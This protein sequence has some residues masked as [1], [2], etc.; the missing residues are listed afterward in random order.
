VKQRGSIVGGKPPN[1]Q[2]DL[3]SALEIRRAHADPPST[4][5]DLR[6][7]RATVQSSA[8]VARET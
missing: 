1:F 6:N 8:T 7:A 5:C 3:R 2:K 4:S